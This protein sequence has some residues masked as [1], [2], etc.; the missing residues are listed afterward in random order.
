MEKPRIG[1]TEFDAAK[2]PHSFFREIYLYETDACG[3]TNNVSFIAYME[4]ARFDLFK[5][6]EL[7]DPGD[8]LTLNLIIA[9]IE[10]DYKKIVRFNDRIVIYTRIQEIRSSS[11]ILEHVFVREED[12]AIVA[13]GK[14]VMVAFDYERGRPQK[15]S[16][17]MT[18]KLKKFCSE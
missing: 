2:Y 16:K 17:E 1:L 12:R 15:L 13:T 6:L 8:V 10:C 5:K 11:F 7:F 14:V 9:R 18:A 3:H 4:N